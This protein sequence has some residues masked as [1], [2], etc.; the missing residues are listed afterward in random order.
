M[1]AMSD[2]AS[3]AVA[4]MAWE[5]MARPRARLKTKIHSLM[6]MAAARMTRVSRLICT[7]W[8]RSRASTDDLPISTPISLSLI[9]I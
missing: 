4:A 2:R 3:A 8:G 5:S 1:E 6:R 7:F 9:H